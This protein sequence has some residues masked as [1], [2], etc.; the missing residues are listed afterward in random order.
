MITLQEL[1][2]A[3]VAIAAT[4]IVTLAPTVANAQTMSTIAGNGT[5]GFSG[6]DKPAI[7]SGLNQPKGIAFD[8]TGNMYIAD[9]TN[10]R[11]RRVTPDGTIST[12][13]GTGTAG[14]NGDG[15]LATGAQLNQPGAIAFDASG[16]MYIADSQNRRVRKVSTSGII[17]TVAGTGVEGYSGDGGAATSAMLHRAVDLAI[18]ASGNVF[19]ADSVDNRVRKISTSGIITTV[20]GTGAAGIAGDS[21]LATSALLNIPSGVAFD[22]AGN[23]YIADARNMRIRKITAS[24][25]IITTVAGNGT[26]AGTDTGSFSGDNGVATSAGLNTPEGVAVNA[27]GDI[28]IADFE[29]YR[30]RKVAAGTNVITTVAGT[31]VD[32][33]SGDGGLAVLATMNLP[34]SVE[35]DATGNVYVGDLMNNRVRKFTATVTFLNTV[36]QDFN[37]DRKSD[38][39]WYNAL[40]GQTAAWLMNGLTQSSSATVLTDPNWKVTNTADLNGDGKAD[41]LWYNAATGQTAAWIMNGLT[42]SSGALLLTDPNWKVTATGDLNGDGKVDLIWYNAASG[43]TAAWIM[44]GLTQSSGTVLL[45]DPNWKVTATGDLNGDGRADLLWYNAANGQT[46]AWL[47]NGLTQSSGTLL[48][49]D[50]NWKIT[51]AIDLNGDA[52]ADLLWYNAAT[53]QTAAWLMNGLTQSSGTLLLQD[54]NWKVM[55]TADLDGDSK[56]DLIWYNAATGQTAGWLMNGL[57]VT[58]SAS[59]FVDQNWKPV[60]A[61]K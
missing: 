27:A 4:I 61:G 19:F 32:G 52:K 17:S 43:Q 45:T 37:G 14:Y 60:Q 42:Q 13:A 58:S 12:V 22:T 57:S 38:L 28:Y 5:A 47:M 21:G 49:Q 33:F 26:G 41:L 44:N 16:N 29:N 36:Q 35:L 40:T 2:K 55:T 48:L 30:I 31:G 15:G 24:T 46:A 10:H 3:I 18:D 9:M 34:W 6:D 8:A 56:T 54:P 25:G 20:A 50:P 23:L 1:K 53:G 51:N 39:I 7:A 59:L 11:V